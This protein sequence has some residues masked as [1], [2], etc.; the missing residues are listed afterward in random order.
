[1]IS[2]AGTWCRPGFVQTQLDPVSV[3]EVT[4]EYRILGPLDALVDG[5]PVN[6]GPP[7]QRALL[8]VLLAQENRLVPAGRIV[9]QLWPDDPPSS[10]DN[11]VQGYVSGLRKALGKDAIETRGA[12][13]VVRV[14]PG[15]LDMSDVRTAGTRG[16]CR[17]RIG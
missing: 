1:M 13:Y 17:S 7:R 15:G 3:A 2:R 12:G 14:E 6:L 5:R 4:R 10:A 16:Q 8:A 11:L 9:D